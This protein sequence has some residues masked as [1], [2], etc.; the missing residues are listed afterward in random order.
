MITEDLLADRTFGIEAAKQF[1]GLG[2]TLLYEL[3]TEG[4]LPFVKVGAPPSDSAA[5]ASPTLY[6]RASQATWPTAAT[7]P[8]EA[9]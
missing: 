2:R 7:T 5:P 9:H 8:G 1:S 3:M 6:P 4:R